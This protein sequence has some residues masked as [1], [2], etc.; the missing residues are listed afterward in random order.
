MKTLQ[1]MISFIAVASVY[2][3]L[4]IDGRKG[5]SELIL[6]SKNKP[7]NNVV[8]RQEHNKAFELRKGDKQLLN[9][10]PSGETTWGMKGNVSYFNVKGGVYHAS[11]I[12]GIVNTE[13]DWSL[14]YF[15]PFE[16]GK[17][18]GWEGSGI[19]RSCGAGNDFAL[20]HN[21][22]SKSQTLSKKIG[23]LPAHKELKIQ[24]SF[25]F[26]DK[27]EGEQAYVK[28]GDHIIW[29]KTRNW[30]KNIFANECLKKGVD[31]CGNSYPDLVGQLVSFSMLHKDREIDFEVGSS[32]PVENCKASWAIDNIMIFTR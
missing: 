22:Q 15:E 28:L 16:S 27:W 1:M 9:I 31:V 14:V 13:K 29:A 32:L 3:N 6:N 5:V 12:D 24:L 30:C 25:H 2:S 17:T 4:T 11:K 10:Q 7:E 18:N 26:L 8:F 20:F 19:L 21:C 23:V